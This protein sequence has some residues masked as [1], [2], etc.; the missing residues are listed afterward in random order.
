M[1]SPETLLTI[2]SILM[3]CA[4]FGDDLVKKFLISRWSKIALPWLIF[5]RL[6]MGFW[7]WVITSIITIKLLSENFFP[8]QSTVIW[9]GSYLVMSSLI[10]WG[11]IVIFIGS[12]RPS[13]P[14]DENDVRTADARLGK[15]IEFPI[16]ILE[17]PIKAVWRLI[18][19][20]RHIARILLVGF[21]WIVG[22]ASAYFVFYIGFSAVSDALSEIPQSTAIVIGAVIIA[23]AITASQ[24]GR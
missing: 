1:R 14:D 5:Q 10:F 3:L 20:F 19:P 15:V 8:E 16:K 22:L 9:D 24:K 7:V 4:I 11:A 2:L 21:I 18:Y 17:P 13:N 23:L 6:I 12:G